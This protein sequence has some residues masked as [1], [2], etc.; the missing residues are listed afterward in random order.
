MFI[1]SIVLVRLRPISC[2]LPRTI[3]EN[4]D[5]YSRVPSP[6]DISLTK[7][8]NKPFSDYVDGAK[9]YLTPRQ[10][11]EATS[12]LISVRTNVRQVMKQEDRTS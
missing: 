3:G 10:T 5:S 12:T 1:F 2:A 4:K 7:D 11:K 9:L 8:E 6:L